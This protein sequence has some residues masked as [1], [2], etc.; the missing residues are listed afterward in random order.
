MIAV[1]F[2]AFVLGTFVTLAA[3]LLMLAIFQFVRRDYY[4]TVID[5]AG[6]C[7][8]LLMAGRWVGWL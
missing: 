4:M 3:V 5:V 7:M 6:E 2:N 8:C 1:M